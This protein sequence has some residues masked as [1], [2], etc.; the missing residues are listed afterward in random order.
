MHT[1][2]DGG[3]NMFVLPQSRFYSIGELTGRIT[4]HPRDR[5]ELI[6]QYKLTLGKNWK[7]AKFSYYDDV[8]GNHKR[9]A[10]LN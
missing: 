9:W 1:G 8:Q 6:L 2:F 4:P 3:T 7:F 10:P 5:A